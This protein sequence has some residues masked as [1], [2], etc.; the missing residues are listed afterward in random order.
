MT[1]SLEHVCTEDRELLEHH[2]PL[3]IDCQNNENSGAEWKSFSMRNNVTLENLHCDETVEGP[4]NLNP[5]QA[6]ER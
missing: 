1:L 2:F 5:D 6:N 3:T 4:F